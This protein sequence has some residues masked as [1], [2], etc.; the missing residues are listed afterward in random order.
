TG[1]VRVAAILHDLGRGDQTRRHGL[2]SIQASKEMAEE[3]LRHLPLSE[4]ARRLV[5]EAIDSHDQ[6]DVHSEAHS[7][8]ILKD[9]DFLAGFG[10]WG[11]LR[12]A[13][14]SGETGRRVEDVLGRITSGMRRRLESLEYP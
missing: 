14:W 3:V 2:A 5:V 11:I 8:R 1:L 12:I 4:D 13:M 9:A 6:P 10:A 7:S